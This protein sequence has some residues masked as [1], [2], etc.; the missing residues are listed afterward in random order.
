[1]KTST[2]GLNLIKQFEG[3]K[4]TAYID[5][6]GIWSIGYGHTKGVK[7]GCSITQEQAER[8]LKEDLAAAE[9]AVSAYHHV[10]HWNQN[11]FDA[12]VSF[13]YNLGAGGIRQVT[14]AGSRDK[15]TI[16]QKMRLYYNAG[17]KKLEGLVRRRQ[18]EHDLFVTPVDGQKDEKL[19]HLEKIL[20]DAIDL[21]AA[22]AAE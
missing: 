2:K 5:P 17:G 3:L 9:E 15:E 4:L 10:Y 16:A 7:E 8:Y 22:I 20:Y 12:L 19:A 14:D 1:M 11:E 18:A 6:V 21:I 13:A